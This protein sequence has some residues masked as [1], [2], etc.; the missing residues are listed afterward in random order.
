MLVTTENKHLAY[1]KIDGRMKKKKYSQISYAEPIF[2]H[3]CQWEKSTGVRAKG[4]CADKYSFWLQLYLFLNLNK[5]NAFPVQFLP[6]Y[7]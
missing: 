5:E 3:W 1:P 2:S 4:V 6:V 7:S